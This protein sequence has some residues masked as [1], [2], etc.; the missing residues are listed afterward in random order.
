MS[1]CEFGG[2]RDSVPWTPS[3]PNEASIFDARVHFVIRVNAKLIYDTSMGFCSWPTRRLSLSLLP[4]SPKFQWRSDFFPLRPHRMSSLIS[5]RFGAGG[6][7][8]G[9]IGGGEEGDDDG[10]DEDDNDADEVRNDD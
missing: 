4:P 5:L 7:G 2:M 3:N 9:G 10:D 8:A 6:T 1:D